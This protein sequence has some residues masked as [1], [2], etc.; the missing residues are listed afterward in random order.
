M[1]NMKKIFYIAGLILLLSA[2]R[3]DIEFDACG[4]I[5]A[6]QVMVSAE[7]S[8]KILYLDLEE[9]DAITAGEMLG[10]IDSMQTYLQILELRQRISGTSSRLIDIAKQGEPNKSQLKSL[11]NELERYEKLLV[12]NAAT[13]KQVE[14]LTDKITILKAQIAAQTQSWERN[15]ATVQSEI[16]G[17]EIQLAQREDQLA[18]CRITAPVSGTV[19]TRYSE[20]GELVTV[21]KPLFKVADL[22]N[23]FV[24]A[25]FTTNQLSDIKLN[26]KVTVIPDDG[27]SSPKRIEGSIIWIS[28]EAEFTPK[29]IQTRDERA[30]MVYAVKVSVPNDGSLRLGMFA[31]VKR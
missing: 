8:G 14:D 19:L 4:Q 28:E 29:N 9:G 6:T 16:R 5:D 17:Y 18:K 25:Y 11:Q 20:T 31:Y 27:S 13:R 21:G 15:N 2:C 12:S 24:R 30:D 1:T 26:D 10:A 7:S 23:T 3:N 22:G